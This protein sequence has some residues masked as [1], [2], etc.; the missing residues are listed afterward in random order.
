MGALA[1][2]RYD[3]PWGAA[4]SHSET[5]HRRRQALQVGGPVARGDLEDTDGGREAFRRHKALELLIEVFRGLQYVDGLRAKSAA[6][7]IAA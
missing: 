2:P 1:A 6:E 7:N 4:L 3:D 5:S